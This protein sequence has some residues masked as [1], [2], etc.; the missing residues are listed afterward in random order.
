MA[1]VRGGLF[2]LLSVGHRLGEGLFSLLV[3]V[4]QTA[5]ASG[6]VLVARGAVVI[7]ILAGGVGFGVGADGTETGVEGSKPS[8]P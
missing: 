1:G 8:Q 2:P 5:I 7:A 4:P 6:Q 3:E